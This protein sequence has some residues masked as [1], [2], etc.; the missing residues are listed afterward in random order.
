MGV[1]LAGYGSFT[2][3]SNTLN[4]YE[5]GVI[6]TTLDLLPLCFS[7]YTIFSIYS[8]DTIKVIYILFFIHDFCQA[9]NNIGL[10]S[11]N[12]Q[13][14][15]NCYIFKTGS[16]SIAYLDPDSSKSKST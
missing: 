1:G 11:I 5:H 16:Y 9:I 2:K 14:W 15:L 6:P 13:I 8:L 12:P 4:Y 3:S 10:K 7:D